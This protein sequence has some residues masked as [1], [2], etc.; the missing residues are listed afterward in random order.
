MTIEEVRRYADENDL[1]IVYFTNP[2]FD[3]SIIGISTD[4]RIIYDYDNMVTELMKTDNIS[5]EEAIEF[6]EY[7]TIR[8]IPY[9]D[10]APIILKYK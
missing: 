1:C 2:N 5:Y 3:K 10:N 6:I 7:N 8:A 9:I 4:D